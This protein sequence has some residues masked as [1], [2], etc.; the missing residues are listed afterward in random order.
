M[1]RLIYKEGFEDQNKLEYI[2]GI[3]IDLLNNYKALIY[4]KYAELTFFLG[5]RKKIDN[6]DEPE[7]NEF[8]SFKVI[9]GKN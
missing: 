8:L 3:E 7:L 4:P 5:Q 6:W 9:N 2:E 1:A